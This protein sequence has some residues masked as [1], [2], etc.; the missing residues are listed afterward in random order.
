MIRAPFAGTVADVDFEVETKLETVPSQQFEI[1]GLLVIENS[2]SWLRFDV[3][4]N[5][6]ELR[7]YAG[8]TVNHDTTTIVVAMATG[9]VS[10][11]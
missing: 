5:G 11:Q 10:S 6:S 2:G 9:A 1:Q 3:Y 7:M 8:R 4:H